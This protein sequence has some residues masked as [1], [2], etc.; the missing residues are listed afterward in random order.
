ML[1]VVMLINVDR[2]FVPSPSRSLYFSLSFRSELFLRFV[3][4]F[5]VWKFPAHHWFVLIWGG[6]SMAYL[7]S[8]KFFYLSSVELNGAS[9]SS[10]CTV[11]EKALFTTPH[12]CDG[13]PHTRIGALS[14]RAGQFTRHTFLF[15]WQPMPD[16]SNGK[17]YK[18]KNTNFF[19]L[20][21]LS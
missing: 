20:R 5:S 8:I 9:S 12:A 10:K 16:S 13:L 21:M 7:V 6:V 18:P 3:I 1:S 15:L 19:D 4:F 14:A 11:R 17:T 2:Q